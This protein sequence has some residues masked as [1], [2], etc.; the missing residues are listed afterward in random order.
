[1]GKAAPTAPVV[2]VVLRRSGQ[3]LLGVVASVSA[4]P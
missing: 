3:E 4:G 1:M 2:E